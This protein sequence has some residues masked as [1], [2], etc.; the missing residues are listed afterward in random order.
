MASVRVPWLERREPLSDMDV[1]FVTR[2]AFVELPDVRL[3][4]RDGRHGGIEVRAE[5][6]GPVE[7]IGGIMPVSPR[8][9]AEGDEFFVIE[10]SRQFARAFERRL[11]AEADRG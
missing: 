10:A 6:C 1:Y 4:T 2:Y 5:W 11:L 9:L 7:R 8:V 3:F